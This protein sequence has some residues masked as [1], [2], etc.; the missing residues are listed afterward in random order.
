MSTAA[1]DRQAREERDCLRAQAAAMS[2]EVKQLVGR[3]G[4]LDVDLAVA[5]YF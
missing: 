3:L 5:S 1:E 4:D 2:P